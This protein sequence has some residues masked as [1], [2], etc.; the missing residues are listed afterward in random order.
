MAAAALPAPGAVAA[1]AAA[2]PVRGFVPGEWVPKHNPWAI[3]LTVTLATFMEVL[4]TSI[5]NVSLPHIAGNL[6]ASQDE[7]AWVLT[8]YLV[9]NAIVLPLSGW[10]SSKVGRKRFYM[11]SVA[12]FTVSSFLCGLAP[13]LPWLVF[14]RILQG[15]G[16]GGLAPSEQAILADTFPASKR[17][18]AM[19][20]YGM[21][22]VMA[23]AIGPTLG[24]YITDNFSWRWIF[25]I[26]VPVGILSLLLSN[27]M[28]EDPPHLVAAKAA[29]KGRKLD[30]TGLILLV[31]GLGSLEVVLDKGQEDDWFH[32][33]FIIA[34]SISAVV[35][36][37][38]FLWWTLK[39]KDPLVDL[40]LFKN[41]NFALSNAMMLVLG[42]VLFGTTILL[43]QFM[44]VV[45]HWDATTSGM[46]L[47]PGAL[48]IVCM[49]PLIG[50]NV[51][52]V[53]ARKMIAF[54]FTMQAV[55]LWYMVTHLST[56]LDLKHA[57]FM[58]CL[59]CIGLAFLFV[60]I[61][62]IV[63]TGIPPQK[64]GSVSGLVNLSRNMG[65]DL[66]ISFVT[67]MISRRSQV[68]QSILAQHETVFDPA[69]RARLASMQGA[70]VHAGAAAPVAE[71]QAYG[72]LYAELTRQSATLSYIDTVWVLMILCAVMVP[73]VLLTKRNRGA[74]PEGAH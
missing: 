5:A 52:K 64:S 56:G 59:Q 13:S 25:L 55:S 37:I 17:G 61:Q 18:Q 19:A 40:R 49:M 9:A 28:V 36:I 41:A 45:M 11:T 32:S 22:V 8:S 53:D 20:V 54:G 29:S 2:A 42:I 57:I 6:S 23:P 44:Q 65:G 14:F 72:S 15:I 67:T 30:F 48:L 24:G 3:A 34:F 62:T 74:M 69:F 1:S 71:K 33:Q 4:D 27:R 51:Q 39:S 12:L 35:G 47:S 21:A 7:S 60:P 73:L 26:N 46:A 70:L 10:I 38:S 31:I 68:H 66:G 16:G 50:K 63:Y 58:R 43:P